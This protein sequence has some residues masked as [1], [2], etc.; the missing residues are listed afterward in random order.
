MHGRQDGR[1]VTVFAIVVLLFTSYA[2]LVIGAADTG[3][4]S[5]TIWSG[6]VILQDGYTVESGEI[7]VVQ[8]GTT[9]QLGDDERIIVA[10]RLTVQG[11]ST[12]PVL[13]ES[14]F[15][16]HHGIVFNSSSAG[17]GSK[18][19]NLTITDAEWGLTIYDL[20]LIHI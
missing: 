6:T 9:I 10:G 17:L 18:I 2:P 5:T 12:A 4:R 20:S 1:R 14:I 8:S 11:T 13:L 15:G 16:D 7:L 19:E 3:T